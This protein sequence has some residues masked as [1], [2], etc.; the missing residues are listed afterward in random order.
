MSTA[1]AFSDSFRITLEELLRNVRLN[2]CWESEEEIARI[3]AEVQEVYEMHRS[4]IARKRVLAGIARRYNR[5]V[6]TLRSWRKDVTPKEIKEYLYSVLPVTATQHEN[7]AYF[8]GAVADTWHGVEETYGKTLHNDAVRARILSIGKEFFH[9]G[10]NLENKVRFCSARFLRTID[11]CLMRGFNG[12][13]N[14]EALRIA[15]L[16]GIFAG[17]ENSVYVRGRTCQY[18]FILKDKEIT[19]QVLRCFVHLG[20]YPAFQDQ[21]I[22]ITGFDDLRKI[23]E[24]GLDF[25]EQNR[26]RVETAITVAGK[27]FSFEKYYALRREVRE[28]LA[29]TGN[30]DFSD[31]NRKYDFPHISI[32]SR[33]TADIVL[34]KYPKFCY[35]KV[36]PRE[37]QRYEA[38]VKRLGPIRRGNEIIMMINGKIIQGRL[39]DACSDVRPDD[40]TIS[41]NITEETYYLP[42]NMQK[43][44]L[45]VYGLEKEDFESEDVEHFTTEL[46]RNLRGDKTRDLQIKFD[47]STKVIKSIILRRSSNGAAL[48]EEKVVEAGRGH[49]DLERM[50]GSV[51]KKYG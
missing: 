3:Q 39:G 6:E 12:F 41:I 26:W 40:G 30:V 21:M 11:Y 45:K 27:A 31:L 51:R 20:I 46:E 4:A 10:Y 13:V 47:P 29:K 23:Q 15:F 9:E 14:S 16:K 28:T 38:L 5:S 34:E 35:S 7:F 19:D 50:Y 36:T 48:W 1:V 22:I 2:N 37:V 33:W 17:T 8:L 18:N 42:L 25:N 44:Y 24:L 32:P 43:K 49:H